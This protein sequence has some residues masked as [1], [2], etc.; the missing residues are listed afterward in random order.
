MESGSSTAKKKLTYAMIGGGPG[1]FIGDVHR[2][3]VRID[4]QAVLVSGIFS[5]DYPRAWH[6]GKAW[7]F[8]R[9][10][11]IAPTRKWRTWKHREKTELTMW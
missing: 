9:I 3:A 6:S 4:D 5:R 10:V 11:Y 1:A 2:T 7:G 8:L